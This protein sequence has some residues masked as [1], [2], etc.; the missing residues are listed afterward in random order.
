MSAQNFFS[1]KK[2]V[3]LAGVA[4]VSALLGLPAVAQMQSSPANSNSPTQCIPSTGQV[5]PSDSPTGGATMEQMQASGTQSM[6][7][8]NIN[9]SS[10]YSGSEQ[11]NSSYLGSQNLQANQ[12]N[13]SGNSSA[14]GMSYR[15]AEVAPTYGPAGGYTMERLRELDGE[16]V[17]SADMRNTTQSFNSSYQSNY[18]A[19]RFTPSAGATAGPAGGYTANSLNNNN[20]P[21][22]NSTAMNQSGENQ[23]SGSNTMRPLPGSMSSDRNRPADEMTAEVSQSLDNQSNSIYRV[24]PSSS[25]S[26]SQSNSGSAI[27]GC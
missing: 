14:A 19:N 22:N 15:S 24:G 9:M 18:Q 21:M 6:D 12:S 11:A 23:Y 4:G 13:M 27:G 5:T 3:S 16:R 20:M 2:V 8:S 1:F 10:P 26:S 7:Q 25:S 17:A